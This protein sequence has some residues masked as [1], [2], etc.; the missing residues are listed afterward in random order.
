MQKFKEGI[1]YPFVEEYNRFI[2]GAFLTDLLQFTGGRNAG[3][4]YIS[5][6]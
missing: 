5:K 3:T 4:D 2:N 6:V 1:Y